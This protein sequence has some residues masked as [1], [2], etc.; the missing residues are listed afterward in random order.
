LLEILFCW[1]YPCNSQNLQ[2]PM[3]YTFYSC[4][5]EGI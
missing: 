4:S 3:I 5:Q 2:N 1:E